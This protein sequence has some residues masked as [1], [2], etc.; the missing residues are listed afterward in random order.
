MT[1]IDW[2]NAVFAAPMAGTSSRAFR[3][4]VRDYG[5][6]VACGEM[7]SAQALCYNNRKTRELIDI[8]GELFPKIV[9]LSGGNVGFI[10][11]AALKLREIGADII[12]LNM[13][14]PVPK[15]VRNGEGAALMQQPQLA[16]ELVRAAREAGLPVSVKIRSGWDQKSINCL[17]FARL[18]E[19]AGAAFITVHGR[20]REQMYRGKADW[21]Q[22]A[23]V[24]EAVGVP[25]IGNGDIFTAADALA[26]RAACGCDA[27]MVGRG[28]LGNPWLFTDIAA[29]YQGRE[30]PGR[31][32]AQQILAQALAHLRREMERARYW[33]KM[34]GADK[35]EE[36]A[37]ATASLR[38]LRAHL[39]FYLKGLRGAAQ[40]RNQ[41]NHLIRYEDIEKLFNQYL[42]L[43]L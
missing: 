12:D 42:Q 15:V 32:D 43:N 9:Q 22:I 25:V 13:G 37:A 2:N 21:R 34:R 39:G 7:I 28:M 41:L 1:E 29:V 10:K 23:A 11:E 5:A 17:E 36:D 35:K 27:V 38:S 8:E 3:E 4:I 26:M 6:T 14:C 18:L 16:A 40:L 20:S 24:K 30:A 31:P 33:A 19:H